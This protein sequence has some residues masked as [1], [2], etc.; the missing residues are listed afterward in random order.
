MG[1]CAVTIAGISPRKNPRS[2]YSQPV[3]EHGLLI[4]PG[5][6]GQDLNFDEVLTAPLPIGPGRPGFDPDRYAAA[7][8]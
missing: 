3:Q 7:G 4:P 8:R 2:G 6:I 1:S 5:S